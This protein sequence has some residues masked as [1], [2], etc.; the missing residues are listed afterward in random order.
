MTDS[1]SIDPVDQT[2]A[3]M[4]ALGLDHEIFDPAATHA[5]LAE[6]IEQSASLDALLAGRSELDPTAFDPGWSADGGADSRDQA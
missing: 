3:R 1:P 4:A 2:A 5:D 6:R